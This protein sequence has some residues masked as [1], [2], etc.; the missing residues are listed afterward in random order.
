MC[1]ATVSHGLGG[2]N[3]R[4]SHRNRAKRFSPTGLERAG[5]KHYKNTQMQYN[6]STE[7]AVQYRISDP[8]NRH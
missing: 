6:Y 2:E 8:A 7:N 4:D 3:L 1:V 5:G